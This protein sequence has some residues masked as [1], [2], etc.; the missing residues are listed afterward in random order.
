MKLHL[1]KLLR[2]AVIACMTAVVSIGTTVGTGVVG[3][4]AVTYMVVGATAAAAEYTNPDDLTVVTFANG[5]VLNLSSGAKVEA[6]LVLDSADSSITLNVT[7]GTVTWNTSQGENNGVSAVNV[8]TGATLEVG[9]V[10]SRYCV[11]ASKEGA[12]VTISL[13]TGAKMITSNLFGWENWGRGDG[14]RVVNMEAGSE[15]TIRDGTSFYLNKTTINLSGGKIKLDGETS[16]MWF[17]RRANS[18][19]TTAA[20][21]QMSVISGTGAIK[22]GNNGSESAGY[23][24]NVV[25]GAFEYDGTNTADLQLSARLLNADNAHGV[26]KTGNG[27][28]EV[29]SDSTGFTH[30][31]FVR[32]GEMMFSG[33]GNI[34][35]GNLN[36]ISGASLTLNT[37][38]AFAGSITLNE[39]SE[40]NIGSNQKL[41]GN[42]K[43]FG[44]VNMVNTATLTGAVT[45]AETTIIDL[46]GWTGGSTYQLFTLD[47]GTVASSRVTV[48]GAEGEGVWV[49]DNTG[50]LALKNSVIWSSGATLTW[51]EGTLFD[52]NMAFSNGMLVEFAAS[53]GDVTATLGENISVSELTVKTGTNLV[54]TG[55]N[56]ATMG[57]LILESSAGVVLDYA[58]A[59]ADSIGSVTAAADSTL[60]VGSNG[61]ILWEKTTFTG[62]VP[63]ILVE[64]KL[65]VKSRRDFNN[66]TLITVDGG[67][68][69]YAYEGFDNEWSGNVVLDNGGKLSV[70][71]GGSD[72]FKWDDANEVKVLNGSVL[73]F[74][75]SRC[76]F[77]NEDKLILKDG[78]VLG[79]G[80]NHGCLDFFDDGAIVSSSGTSSIEA[81]IRL[82]SAGATTTFQV[83]DGTLTLTETC[84]KGGGA[85]GNLAKTGTGTLLVTGNL[86]HK[87]TTTVSE[88]TLKLTGTAF[89]KATSDVMMGGGTL[90]LDTQNAAA[91]AGITGTGAVTV[92]S[93]AVGAA[94]DTITDFGGTI[95][96]ADGGDLTIGAVSLAADKNLTVTGA[97][98]AAETFD[99]TGTGQLTLDM[100]N[101]QGSFK[102]NGYSALSVNSLSVALNTELVYGEGDVLEI[103]SVTQA[104]TLN[105]YGVASSLAEGVNTGISLA[106]GQ[107]L[108]DLKA[109]LTVDA[110]DSFTLVEKEGLVWLTSTST[111]QSDWDINWG[112]ILANAPTEL[113]ELGQGAIVT[114]QVE[115]KTAADTIQGIDYAEGGVVAISVN[116]TKADNELFVAGGMV[117]NIGS[118]IEAVS[119][120]S[121]WIEVAGGT[122]TNILGGVVGN[123]WGGGTGVAT[124]EG[125]THILMREGTT[126]YVIGGNM[127]D[128]NGVTSFTG[129]SYISVYEGAT[130]KTAV[131]GGSTTAHGSGT[132]FTGSTNVFVYTCMGAGSY[133]VGGNFQIAG[134]PTTNILTGSTNVTVDLSSYSGDA[135]AFAGAVIGGGLTYYQ[136]SQGWSGGSMM[137]IN[138]DTN[139]NI[140]GKEGVTFTGLI[141]GGGYAMYYGDWGTRNP[142]ALIKGSTNVNITGGTYDATVMGGSYLALGSNNTATS[143]ID[144]TNVNITGGTF[145]GMVLGG[146]WHNHEGGVSTVG[147]ITISVSGTDASLTGNLIGASH[148]Y[149][150]GNTMTTGNVSINLE[151][152]AC[153]AFI[154]GGYLVNGTG[155]A[156]LS[157]T[158]GD[159]TITVDGAETA[160]IY[161][162]SVIHRN[163]ADATVTQGAI[164]LNL[165]SGSVGGDVYVGGWQNGSTLLSTDSTTVNISSDIEIAEGKTIS[166]GYRYGADKTGSTITGDASLVF[167]DGETYSNVSGVAFADFNIVEVAESGEVVTKEM[168]VLKGAL[169]KNGAGAFSVTDKP[170]AVDTITM[171]G[172]S[173]TFAY[174]VTTTGLTANVTAPSK[175]AL[176]KDLTL[177]ALNIDLTG[178][179]AGES[180]ID[181]TGALTSNGKVTV[182]LTGVSTLQD[183][184]DYILL[185]STSTALTTDDLISTLDAEAPEGMEYSVVIE[186]N[187]IIFRSAHVSD[188]VW[189][190]TTDGE[191]NVW[192]DNAD[193]WKAD[194]DGLTPNGQ[195]VYFTAAGA[196]E[197]VVSGEVTP[198]NVNI[199]GG[200]YTFTAADADSGIKLGTDGVMSISAGVVVNMAMDN[201]ELGGSTVLGGKLVLQ[202]ADAVGNTALKFNGGTLVY[203]TLTDDGGNKTHISTDLSTQASLADDYTGPVK[204]EVTDAE[205]VVTWGG[206]NKYKTDVPGVQAALENG[207]EYNAES[208]EGTMH[209]MFKISSNQ[210]FSGGINVG[211]GEFYY[212]VG[213]STPTFTGAITVAEGAKLGFRTTR[214]TI[215]SDSFLKVS[216][217]ITGSGTVE[218]GEQGVSSGRYEFSGDNSAFAGTILLSGNNSS[219]TDNRALFTSAAA[220]G[221]T[222]TTVEVNGRGFLFSDSVTAVSSVK[223]T[224]ATEGNLL[225]GGDGKTYTFTGAWIGDET[226][227]FTAVNASMTIGLAGDLSD[228]KGYLKSDAKNT[229]VLGGSGV[230]GNG[231][232]D[233]QELKGSGLFVVQYSSETTLNAVVSESAKL[234]QSGTGKLILAAENTST[235]TLT[236]DADKEVQLGAAN[237]AGSWAGSELAGE[238]TMTLV[239]GAL[240]GLTKKADTATLAVKTTKKEVSTFALGAGG[241]TVVDMTGSDA[242]LL[243]SIELAEGSTLI[244]DDDLTVGGTGNTT[245]KMAF[246]TDNVGASRIDIVAMIQGGDVTI[247]GT[248]GVNLNMN[249]ADVLTAL[250]NADGSDLYLQVTDGALDVGDGV[251]INSVITPDLIGMGVRA[252]LTDEAK[253]GGYVIINGDVSGVYFTDNQEGSSAD[254]ADTVTVKD[255][256][257][258]IY[259]GVVINKDDTLSVGTSTTINNLNG[260]EGGNLVITDNSSVVLNNSQLETG[261]DG[262]DPMGATNV[263]AGNL[264]GEEGTTITVDGAGGKLTVGGD[265]T[266]DALTVAAGDLVA[267]GGGVVDALTVSDGATMTVGTGKSLEL[268]NGSIAGVLKADA[269]GADL[270]TQGQVSVSGTI[271]NMDMTVEDGSLVYL[272]NGEAYLNSLTVDSGATVMGTNGL[273][274]VGASGSI[275]G[276]LTGS[277]TLS[278]SAGTSLTFDNA[279]GSAGWNVTN[280]GDMTLDLTESGNLTLGALELANG[281]S[282]NV[283]FNSD[284]GTDGLLTLKDLTVGDTADITLSSTGSG[285]IAAGEYTL[286]TVDGT[287]DGA[288]ELTVNFSG[289]AFSQLD[290]VNSY[291]YVDD[292]GNIVL[293]AVKSE[294]NTLAESATD[295]NAEAGAELLWNATA[296]VGGDLESAYNAVNQM[297]AAGDAAG[298]NETMAAV[299]GASTAALGMA[300]AGDLERQLRAIRNRTTTMGVNQCVVNEGMPYVNAWVNAEG[301]R[302]SLDTD[303]VASGYELDSW[304]GT[305]GLDVDVNPNLTV[306]LAL[307]AMYGNLTVDGP[308]TLEGD[309]DTYYVSAFARYSSGAWTHTFIGTIGMMDATTERTVNYGNGAYTAEGSTTGTAFGLMYEIGRVYALDDKGDTCLQP[310]FNV[311]YRHATV[312][313]FEE[314]NS[315]AGLRVDDQTVDT[316][317]FGAGA[318]LQTVVGENTFNRTSLLELRA[319]AKLDVGDTTSEADV[320]LINGTGKGIIESAEM[321]AFGVELGMGLHIPVGD[322]NDGTIFIDVSAEFRSGYTNI[323]GTVGYRINF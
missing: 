255:S 62:A 316:V 163:K 109:L 63:N 185:T 46:T 159:I 180:Y 37:S 284:N 178:T 56:K 11:F 6:P 233:M 293:N 296:P 176:G 94:I 143:T 15:W 110:V 69:V 276:K 106:E 83:T 288:D 222:G 152:G 248:E 174:G 52:G 246:T 192:A 309:M 1:P 68:L 12:P 305:V 133:V 31:F 295:P 221:G 199:T 113:T 323:N 81:P 105:V 181:V 134:S 64:G 126:D 189:E 65:T 239:Y 86:S 184:G 151:G 137:Q 122:Y 95:T 58:A 254:T 14:A 115:G 19:N 154:T 70:V 120:D 153:S 271:S 287:Y 32:E 215:A 78:S 207:I 220:F 186:N 238:G 150:G 292:Q 225:G 59:D 16:Y 127:N 125:D 10:D 283:L 234:Q 44:T 229:W 24:F 301:D 275:A 43:L 158:I 268:N 169:T 5:D 307:T 21:T 300:F 315:D 277:G 42:N 3:M 8:A 145:N 214:A 40:L 175:L 67:E 219:S 141:V 252:L 119:V 79:T 102:M 200:E 99:K 77:Q 2:K 7:A 321:G 259:A 320:A 265:L 299:A 90:A 123:N 190:G 286:G 191:T 18:I 237:A 243:D 312:G 22:A 160:E 187:N 205:N 230:A 314:E 318:R 33:A 179:T 170:V 270:N 182:N 251:D 29:T 188:W 66:A 53:Q 263:L 264:T 297:I 164:V 289:T 302:R 47:G 50:L 224:G 223:V 208:G 111:V 308:D 167:T 291:I 250:N 38:A 55:D 57:S 161:G 310:V 303:G 256:S 278:T 27:R 28:M 253:A 75:T 244:V 203:D 82:R 280:K 165:L 118:S 49:L 267:A 217:A 168:S 25:R 196:G 108:D 132:K 84:D 13:A 311:A 89:I 131:V 155:S 226:S 54:L 148:V 198:A 273:V 156:N 101:V 92:A 45:V 204:I 260:Q 35:S 73:D 144:S 279:I 146:S 210:T 290:K 313:S 285:Q 72:I 211:G 100:L 26:Q 231:S 282:T 116:A 218:V 121:V 107:S 9:D 298:A 317:T 306:G 173:M 117:G 162:G 232:L 272:N 85:S 258:E 114:K 266:A 212:T 97:V 228:Y 17:E 257:L 274:D 262:Y 36:V 34:G 142:G 171:N 71:T 249:N 197:V 261:V 322:E 60:A 96:V 177:A 227:G 304:G 23:T 149:T 80:D 209:M 216:G 76:S 294:D 172:G 235:G 247:A 74:G 245:L 98:T 281:S 140:T 61:D 240:T 166:G 103:G 183:A 128:A 48:V 139:V 236:V 269:S 206:T 30:S 4:G 112:A 124:F 39:G 130:V 136:T 91:V 20:A 129:D 93:T 319:M 87:G 135:T 51:Q 88:G 104:V 201:A 138:E 202:S 41:A 147:D 213:E 157:A 241:G 195:D 242:G 193:G 194:G